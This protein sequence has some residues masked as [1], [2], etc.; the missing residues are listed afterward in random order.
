MNLAVANED[1]NIYLFD[2]RKF[3]RALNVLKNHV[4][5]VMDVGTYI[6]FAALRRF[7]QNTNTQ[8]PL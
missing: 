5:A 7:W 6:H 8:H 4:A 2:M 3:D 1:H